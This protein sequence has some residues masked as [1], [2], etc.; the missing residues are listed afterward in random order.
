M[1]TSG[2]VRW[3]TCGNDHAAV[4]AKA[5]ATS[6]DVEHAPHF[7]SL[8]SIA[9]ETQVNAAPGGHCK[10]SKENMPYLECLPTCTV[11]A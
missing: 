2:A 1:T 7:R 9:F 4:V 3:F 6:A 10:V 5:G 11:L 8:L